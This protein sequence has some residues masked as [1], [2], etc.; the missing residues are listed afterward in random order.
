MKT[1]GKRRKDRELRMNNGKFVLPMDGVYIVYFL[2]GALL[3]FGA[4]A[5]HKKNWNEDAF[6]LKQTKM[7]QG[8]TAVCIMFHHM[9]QKT[10]APWHES[11]VIVYGLEPFV[12]VGYY[13]VAVFLFC[14]GFGLYKS[15][16]AKPDYL[17]HFPR[18]RILPIVVAFYLSEWIY[19]GVRALMGEKM[20]TGK[21]IA[22]LTG[23]QLANT[24]AWYVIAIPFFY[25]FFWLA[26]RFCKRE[27]TAIAWVTV[28]ILAY[29]VLG[30]LVDHNDW[31]MCGEWWYN[32]ALVF[33]LGILFG[34]YEKTI[35][36]RLKKGYWLWLILAF[37]GTFALFKLA[38]YLTDTAW[39]Y[40]GEWGDPL[41]VQH[42]LGCALS[43][44]LASFSYVCFLFIAMMKIRIGNKALEI[45]GGL[46]LEIYL[47]HG[48]FVEMFGFDFM[49]KVH[50][51]TYIRN[52]GLYVLAVVAC[53]VVGTF[54]FR[55]LYKNVMK[56][57]REKKPALPV[58]AEAEKTA[59]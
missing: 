2:L 42:R 50:S 9:A 53:T 54:L 13:F 26:F 44:N 22:Y 3:L 38:I 1:C 4:R 49:E 10:G 55:L 51:I 16:K 59:E 17:K 18:R 5:V 57:F 23:A 25:L 12:Q 28:G 39:G 15:F 45:L 43:Q 14:S 48:L 27:G 19:T 36:E 20:N 21:L 33:V 30:A 40:Y 41:K 37:V 47:I 24:N 58:A 8:F 7:L 56:L 35:T 52:V 46:T 29:M 31:W 34:K 32:T 6:S 11:R